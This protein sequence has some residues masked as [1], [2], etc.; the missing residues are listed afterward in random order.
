[1]TANAIVPT[2]K[3]PL[4]KYF[5]QRHQLFSRFDQGILLDEEGWYSVT[6]ERIGQHLAQRCR[7]RTIVDAFCGVGG[8]AIQFAL[9]C[10][11]VI[12]IDID[13]D[14][15]ELARHNARIYGVE[16]RIEFIHGDFF[17]VMTTW[18]QQPD[19]PTIDGVFMS[20]P[21]GGPDYLQQTYFDVD[22]MLKPRGTQGLLDFVRNQ[23]TPNMCLYLPRNVNVQ[24]LRRAVGE[25]FDLEMNQVNGRV[26][27]VSVY[28]G[29]FRQSQRP[30]TGA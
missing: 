11:H 23:V 2:P 29:Q 1:M 20:P 24:Q 12:A 15:L 19:R 9:T 13:A 3:H 27:T 5:V 26:K 18:H 17:N 25:D 28:T 10:D 6:P 21:W 16:D 22:A 14:R 4:Y 7:C 30:Q 8:N